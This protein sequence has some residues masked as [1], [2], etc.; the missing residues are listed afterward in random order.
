MS[1][2]CCSSNVVSSPPFSQGVNGCGTYLSNPGI[3]SVMSW[4]VGC[5]TR[6]NTQ[7]CW[8]VFAQC[9]AFFVELFHF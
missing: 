3:T 1:N 8:V 5:L 9:R 6:E 4:A 2:Y 7:E